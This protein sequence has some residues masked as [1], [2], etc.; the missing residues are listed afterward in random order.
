M[1][2]TAAVTTAFSGVGLLISLSAGVGLSNRRRGKLTDESVFSNTFL[3]CGAVLDDLA[4]LFSM[5]ALSL[6]SVDEVDFLAIE[7]DVVRRLSLLTEPA[8]GVVLLAVAAV[9]FLS[10]FF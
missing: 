6:L 5:L 1:K 8:T 10:V 9:T 3:G 4:T 2:L 7:V